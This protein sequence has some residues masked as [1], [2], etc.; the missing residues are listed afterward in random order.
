LD[1]DITIIGLGPAGLQAAIHAARRKVKVVAVGRSDNSALMRAEVE[2]YLGLESISGKEIIR[3]GREQAKKFGAELLDEDVIK[4]TKEGDVFV[5]ITDSDREIRSK[6]VILAMGISRAKLNIPGE[7]ELLGKGVSYCASCDAGFF[8]GRPVAVIGEESEAAE[9]ALLLSEIA[10]KVYWVHRELKASQHM[11]EKVRRTKVEMVQGRP[12]RIIGDPTVSGLEL[13]GGRTLEV[14]GVFIALGAKGSIE[15]ALDLGIMPDPSGMIA[16]DADCRTEM[17]MVY[18]CGDVT[19]NPWQ[20]AR[21]VGQG[22]IAGE[23]A[24]K[25]VRQGK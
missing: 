22:C 23:N 7:K 2:N 14:N 19:G 10:S 8:K 17:E 9:S 5:T 21:A 6:A 24:A 3:V 16:V 18:A 1:A 4:L 12:L 13:E 15:L 25:A 11:L 20:L